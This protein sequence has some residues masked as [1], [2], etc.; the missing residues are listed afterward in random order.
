MAKGESS[1]H[2]R[3]AAAPRGSV[4]LTDLRYSISQ[5]RTNF[6]RVRGHVRSNQLD[7]GIKPDFITFV[8]LACEIYRDAEDLVPM[9]QYP[10]DLETYQGKGHTSLVSHTVVSKLAASNIT[11]GSKLSSAEN[12]VI[13]RP[14]GSILDPNAAALSSFITEL[15][16]RTH[17]PLQTH[18]GIARLKGI[19]WDF[20]DREATI[21]RPILLEE[22]APQGALDSFW[23]NWSFVR[24]SFESKLDFCRQI[25]AGLVALHCHGVVHGDVKPENIL[26]FPLSSVRDSFMVKLTDFGHSVLEQDGLDVL[27]AFTPLWCAPEA[28][29]EA[30]M[31]FLEMASTD[32]Y[33]YGLVVLSIILGYA[34]HSHNAFGEVEVCKANGEILQ[35]AIEEVK[36]E[37]KENHDSDLD[38]S[39]VSAL[40]GS[41]I[42]L[43]PRLRSMMHCLW[44]IDR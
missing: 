25:G 37:D 18:H 6:T 23:K 34:F 15:R 5:T 20:E 21:P 9:Q 42:Q 41:T 16:V 43:S 13:K 17:P 4:N 30:K 31:T 1:T 19:G 36:K 40:L 28:K 33:S 14:R 8:S 12:V 44:V 10:P 27:P 29:K 2:T 38:V 7:D 39:T 24:M 32:C 35:L 11:R 3:V 22:W 26:V